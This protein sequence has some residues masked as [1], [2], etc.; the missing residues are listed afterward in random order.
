MT[1]NRTW[2]HRRRY[3][4][5]GGRRS[6]IRM[7]RRRPEVGARR[8]PITTTAA[9]RRRTP[10]CD[11]QF[12]LA[13][14]RWLRNGSSGLAA[15]G[16]KA[17]EPGVQTGNAPPCIGPV[18]PSARTRGRPLDRFQRH[19]KPQ[20][21]VRLAVIRRSRGPSISA[22][23]A[24]PDDREYSCHLKSTLSGKPRWGRHGSPDDSA[25]TRYR[26]ST[27]LRTPSRLITTM[28]SSPDSVPSRCRSKTTAPWRW[29]IG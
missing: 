16:H 21:N 9:A 1:K 19:P 4:P 17:P 25:R 7:P 23:H 28:S 20:A 2:R 12:A 11:G 6:G 3:R 8:W 22:K 26:R 14:V 10:R 29:S 18:P 13:G 15:P 27:W 24:S 5:P